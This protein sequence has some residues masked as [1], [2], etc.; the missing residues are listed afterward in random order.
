MCVVQCRNEKHIPC[1]NYY[2]DIVF[3]LAQTR[4]QLRFA[5]LS[6]DLF[7][8]EA[9]IIEGCLYG[10]VYGSPTLPQCG[11]TTHIYLTL[12][13]EKPTKVRFRFNVVC[14]AYS[15]WGIGCELLGF[16]QAD[17]QTA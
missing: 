3:A 2:G 6:R 11:P 17:K 14:F 1:T 10:K 5:Q 8:I 7:K 12:P 16:G 4:F 13:T 9:I 15:H